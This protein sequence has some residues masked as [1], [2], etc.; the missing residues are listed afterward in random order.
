MQRACGCALGNCGLSMARLRGHV[1]EFGWTPYK[2]KP[3]QIQRSARKL[4][5]SARQSAE[6]TTELCL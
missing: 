3:L 6:T 2:R 1:L 5:L 4:Y